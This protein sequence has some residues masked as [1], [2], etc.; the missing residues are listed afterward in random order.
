MRIGVPSEKVY[1]LPIPASIFPDCTC[2]HCVAYFRL[3][4]REARSW[5]WRAPAVARAR[6]PP[7]VAGCWVDRVVRTS[8]QKLVDEGGKA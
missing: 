1:L 3:T 5:C 8:K 7:S 4:D 6:R 2:F